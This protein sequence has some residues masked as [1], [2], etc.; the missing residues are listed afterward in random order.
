MSSRPVQGPTQP[1]IQWVPGAISPG[2]KR[3]ER[4]GD[5]S[6]PTSAEVKKTWIYTST[7]PHA[8]MALSTGTT[9]PFIIT[10]III[11]PAKNMHEVVEDY[12]TKSVAA[13]K[14]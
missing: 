12:F 3:L 7:P 6:H 10:I 5:H 4:E 1:P 2:I 9:L 8:F 13:L 14:D 11:N